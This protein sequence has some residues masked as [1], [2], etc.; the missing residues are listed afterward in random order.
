MQ[1][2]TREERSIGKMNN[3]DETVYTLDDVVGILKTSKQQVRKMLKN[4][5]L[6]GFKLGKYK[7]KVPRAELERYIKERMM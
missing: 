2:S 3:C 4:G 6:K 7:W 5:E 1:L